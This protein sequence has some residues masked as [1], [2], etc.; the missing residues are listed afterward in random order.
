MKRTKVTF[1]VI[2]WTIVG[3]LYAPIFILAWLLKSIARLLL[4]I[5][6]FG[7]LDGKMGKAVFKS[8]FKMYSKI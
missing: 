2:M 7:L 4:A 6:Y 3:I 8:V 5:S 1:F